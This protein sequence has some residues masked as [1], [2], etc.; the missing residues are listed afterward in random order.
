MRNTWDLGLISFIIYVNELLLT[1]T[2]C[3]ILSF[4]DDTVILYADST[5]SQLKT[6]TERH[7]T[8]TK[9]Y[10]RKL[11]LRKSD[12]YLS[13]HYLKRYLYGKLKNRK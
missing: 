8:E 13:L 2:K 12:T 11:T 5:Y 9:K 10:L 4:V 1:H 3:E 7:V 6:S